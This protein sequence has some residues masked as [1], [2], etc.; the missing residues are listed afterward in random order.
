M[1]VCRWLQQS[2][3]WVVASIW[4]INFS[5]GNGN[6]GIGCFNYHAEDICGPQQSQACM[7]FLKLDGFLK[8]EL[9]NT[10]PRGPVFKT[11]CLQDTLLT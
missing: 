2:P 5:Y 4:P 3:T 7:Q 9:G 1:Y 8:L 11:C 6:L 10:I